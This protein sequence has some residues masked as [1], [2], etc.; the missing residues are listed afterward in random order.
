M[1]NT[2][3]NT[4]YGMHLYP[5]DGHDTGTYIFVKR[6]NN[7]IIDK[8]YVT[9]YAPK[10]TLNITGQSIVPTN[11][12]DQCN[13]HGTCQNNRCNCSSSVNISFLKYE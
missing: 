13:S 12:E 1:Y 5:S 2:G 11:C 6:F 4:Y 8:F 7:D 9:L 10:G 3:K